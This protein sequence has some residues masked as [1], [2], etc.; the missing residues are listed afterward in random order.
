MRR[1]IANASAALLLLL[2]GCSS[3][4]S[5]SATTE[6]TETTDS[7]D[8]Q[9]ASADLTPEE[10][11]YCA[12]LA[13]LPEGGDPG[14]DAFFTEHPEPTLADWAEILPNVIDNL[15]AGLVAFDAVEAPPSMADA[16]QDVH[17]AMTAVGD[18]LD[19][20]LAAA[21]AGDQAAYDAAEAENQGK[22]SATMEEA[23]NV[24]GGVCGLGG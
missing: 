19:V 8:T 15:R 12:E 13:A 5:S 22:L 24:L 6:A 21:E 7:D 1:L 9:S 17:D 11:A 20:G 10:E 2:I 16:R 18:S 23:M 4:D 3:D 14:F